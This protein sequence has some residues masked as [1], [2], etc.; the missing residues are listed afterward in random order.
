MASEAG[1][2]YWSIIPKIKDGSTSQVASDLGAMGKKAGDTAG[3]KAGVSMSTAMSSALKT[4]TKVAFAGAATVAGTA[5]YKGFGRLKAIDEARAKLTGL[6]HSASTVQ[7]IMDNALES[8]RG[9]AFGLDSAATVAASAVA[10]NIKPGQDLTRTLKLVADAATIAGTDMGSMG[11][12]FG[13]VAA[14]NKV[15]MDVINQLHDRGVPALQLLAKQLGVTAEEASKMASKGKINFATFQAAM[16]KGLGGA[17]LKSGETFSGSLANL[18]AALGRIGAN[19]LS[20]IFPK[21]TDEMGDATEAL[22]KL[23]PK[24]KEVGERIAEFATEVG[25]IA[26]DAFTMIADAAK[27]IGPVVKDMVTGFNQLPGAA[28]KIALLGAAAWAIKT[29]FDIAVPSIRSLGTE[30]GKTALATGVMRTG[31]AAL[32]IGLVG[33]AGQ[34]GGASS[35]LGGLM[36]VIGSGVAGSAFG[37]FGALVGTASGLLQVFGAR[38]N[39]AAAAQAKLDAAAEQVA[40]TLDRQ[41]GALTKNT[42]ETVANNLASS[43]AYDAARKVGISLDEMTK[44]ALGDEAAIRRVTTQTLAW[45]NAQKGGVEQMGRT[46]AVVKTITDA[47]NT[48]SDAIARERR[49]INQVK[50]AMKGLDGKKATVKVT[51]DVSAFN[52]AVRR[53]LSNLPFI[54]IGKSKGGGFATGGYTGPGGKHQVAGVVHRDEFVVRKEARR[55]AEAAK[56]GALDYLNKTGQWPGYANGGRVAGAPGQDSPRATST[57]RI[58]PADIQ[59]IVIGLMNAAAAGTQSEFGMRDTIGRMYA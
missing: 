23:E 4:G 22:G 2:S 17:A 43:G 32:G 40:A 9:T 15:Q 7:T 37:P 10:S 51:A 20:G 29:K 38:S 41:T 25:P 3:K 45:A 27:V 5:L 52:A 42:K 8:V 53:A 58:H 18:N 36:T 28:K 34:A 56:P 35:S 44:A 30:A 50:E 16:E 24:A 31:A 14:S 48:N 59:A 55:R 49:E 54:S 33:L 57:V 6:G 21:L 11:A 47:V 12:I 39:D 19:V 46:G 26:A 1:W 13:K